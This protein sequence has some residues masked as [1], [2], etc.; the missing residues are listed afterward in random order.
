MWGENGHFLHICD[1]GILIST[2]EGALNFYIKSIWPIAWPVSNLASNSGINLCERITNHFKFVWPF[3]KEVTALPH[4]SLRAHEA[5][6]KPAVTALHHQACSCW[7]LQHWQRYLNMSE[8]ERHARWWVQVL[9]AVVGW[10]SQSMETTWRTLRWMLH[11][12]INSFC[13][14][15]PTSPSVEKQ[16]LLFHPWEE[17]CSAGRAGSL[18]QQLHVFLVI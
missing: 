10:Q 4:T 1:K 12:S 15:G 5:A 6:R 9:S 13:W 2:A 18:F 17:K 7:R 14:C 3:F 11:W 16:D 8:H